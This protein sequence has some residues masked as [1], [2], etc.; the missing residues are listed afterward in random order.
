MCG[1][2]TRRV[3]ECLKKESPIK[4]SRYYDAERSVLVA[5]LHPVQTK[6][7]RATPSFRLVLDCWS[8][9]HEDKRG[10][11]ARASPPPFRPPFFL[12]VQP[13]CGLL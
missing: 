9:I 3:G 13:T 2:L 12:E 6:K 7:S 4:L 1:E 11:V 8:K 10:R 5:G